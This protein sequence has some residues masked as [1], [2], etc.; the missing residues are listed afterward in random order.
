M[1]E[2]DSKGEREREG[3]FKLSL[4]NKATFLVS[5]KAVQNGARWRQ[6]YVR[7]KARHR[8]YR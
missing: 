2:T 4:L 3:E 6:F 8:N 7:L 1:P 5:E